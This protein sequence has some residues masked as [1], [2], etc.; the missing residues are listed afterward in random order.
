MSYSSEYPP[1]YVTVD[2]VI[3]TIREGAFSVLLVERGGEP[4]A[5]QWALPGGFVQ[6]DED[7][8]DAAYRE[9]E[10][11]TGVRRNS[12]HLEQLATFGR[13]DRDPRH[14]VVSTAY[15][16]VGADLPEVRGG[17]D[18]SDARWW[19]VSNALEQD[20]AF[21]HRQI[22]EAGVERARAKLEYSDLALRFV[23]RNFSMPELQAVYET[24]WGV[25][26][27]PRNF[28]RK[29]ARTERFVR[30]TGEARRGGRGRPARLYEAAGATELMP[31]M[32]RD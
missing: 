30:E 24:V 5:G 2:L 16:A 6:I 31:P 15:L 18:A 11:E 12:V 10:E 7:L 25:E 14:R 23:P 32:R 17:S 26:L 3:L 28:V 13:P 9:L 27:D 4:F 19:P 1:F 8:A 22:L 20:L 29:V 21:D